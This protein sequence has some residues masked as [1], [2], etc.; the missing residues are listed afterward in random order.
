MNKTNATINLTMQMTQ[1]EESSKT[2]Y[3]TDAN[4]LEKD[5]KFF[6]FFDEENEVDKVITNC[7]FEINNDSLRMRRNG[8]I[9]VEQKHLSGQ[10]TDGY[11]KTP[12]GHLDTKIQTHEFSFTLTT[13]AYYDL[14]LSYDLYT[15]AEKTGT[16]S[17][18][19]TIM[20]KEQ[21]IS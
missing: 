1:G 13:N 12:F 5:G 20:M 21:I 8:P 3:E 16:Y 15:E 9:V 19:M 14:D 11:I 4:F 7:R 10:K 17:L 2:S 6:L 18:N